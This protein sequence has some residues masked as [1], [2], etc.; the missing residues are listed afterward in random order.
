[1]IIIMDDDIFEGEESFT[2]AIRNLTGFENVR[3]TVFIQD[4]EGEFKKSYLSSGLN[5]MKPPSTL[6][7]IEMA[8]G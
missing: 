4:N 2:L 8:Q 1:M 5:P 7:N 3:T 6:K